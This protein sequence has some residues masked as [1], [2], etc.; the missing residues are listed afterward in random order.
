MR[1]N[2][3]KAALVRKEIGAGIWKSW[4]YCQNSGIAAI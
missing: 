4:S 1:K 3:G 2:E